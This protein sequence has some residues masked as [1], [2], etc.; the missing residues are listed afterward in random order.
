VQIDLFDPMRHFSIYVPHLAVSALH[1]QIPRLILHYSGKGG[2]TPAELRN[3][4]L[5]KAILALSVRHISLNPSDA[6]E[7][8][9]GRND[10]LQYYYETLHYVQKAMQYDTYHKSLEV[11]ATCLIISAYEMLDGSR[12]DWERHLEG[13]FKIQRSRV[14][15]GDSKGLEAAV[16]WAWLSQDVWAAFR[17]K[18][19]VFTFWK[20]AR[21][22]SELNSHELASR[23]VFIMAHVINYCSQGEIDAGERN[24]KARIEKADS[25][26][27]TLDDWKN[28]LTIEFSPLPLSASSPRDQFDPIWIQP[29]SFGNYRLS[30]A[31]SS[32]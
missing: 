17:E 21:R 18:R 23:S 12:S 5:M 30:K 2:L 25:L 22:F 15:H 20:P 27:R 19:K 24:I 8:P 11:L 10:A 14:I 16:W 28:A 31:S 26:T 3:V 1:S 29:S 13:V 7:K 32:R 6:Y 4:G 9:L